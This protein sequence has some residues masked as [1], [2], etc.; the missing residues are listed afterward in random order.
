MARVGGR[1]LCGSKQCLGAVKCGMTETAEGH[2]GG[3]VTGMWAGSAEGRTEDTFGNQGPTGSAGSCRC[4]S[5]KCF[6]EQRA[7]SPEELRS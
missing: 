5:R 7:A 4:C 2:C 1:D 6:G 3:L